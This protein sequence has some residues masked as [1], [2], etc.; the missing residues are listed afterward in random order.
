MNNVWSVWHDDEMWIV[1]HCPQDTD[2]TGPFSWRW[3][4]TEH[5]LFSGGQPVFRFPSWMALG[6]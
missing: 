2:T 6:G 3:G 1:E 5:F 4:V